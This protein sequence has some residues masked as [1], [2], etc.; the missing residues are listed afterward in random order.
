MRYKDF[1]TDNMIQALTDMFPVESNI[2]IARKLGV[3]ESAV[4]VKGR[5]L[6]LKKGVKRKTVENE[7]SVRALIPYHSYT[8][9]SRLVGISRA[10]VR[11][12]AKKLNLDIDASERV[13]IRRRV[14]NELIRKEKA[15]VIWGLDQISN[16]KVVTNSRKISPR[17]RM[18]RIGYTCHRGGNTL[19]YH[20]RME[21]NIRLETMGRTLGLR[22][23][24]VTS[25]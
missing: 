6:G 12:I 14:R 4:S 23:E 3:S 22:F 19:Y 25:L 21:R 11:R 24:S 1:W 8:E 18:R 16:I 20:D 13:N 15:R 17:Y 5:E 9:I 2:S 7:E 10:A